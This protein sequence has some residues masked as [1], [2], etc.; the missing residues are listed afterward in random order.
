MI[1]IMRVKKNQLMRF[2]GNT[3]SE[4]FERKNQN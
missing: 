1:L 2:E 3:N 4:D